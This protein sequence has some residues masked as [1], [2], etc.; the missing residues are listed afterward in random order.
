MVDNLKDTVECEIC[1]RRFV[2]INAQHLKSHNTTIFEYKKLYPNGKFNFQKDRTYEELYGE[3]RANKISSK[4]TNKNT[5]KKRSLKTI[6]NIKKNHKGMLGHN[7]T[8][9]PCLKCGKIHGHPRSMK[10]KH[11]S[12]EKKNKISKRLKE[13]KTG[14]TFIDLYGIEKA[15][16]IKKK[17]SA[18]KKGVPQTEESKAKHIKGRIEHP[19]SEKS[20]EKLRQRMLSNKFALGHKCSDNTL[21]LMSILSKKRWENIEYREKQTQLILEAL[22]IKPTSIENT[23]FNII[24]A[25]YKLPFKYCGD[26]SF[27]IGNKNPDG[28]INDG[29]QICVEINGSYWHKPEDEQERINYFAKYGWKCIVIWDYELKNVVEVVNKV[30]NNL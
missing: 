13:I 24:C 23:F 8:D 20:R 10:G 22:M 6:E 30:R 26:G 17:I 19:M 29:R 3:E 21:E 9:T 28:I 15:N 11:C 12:E 14:K 7:R 1:H 18:A 27:L 25:K 2:F 4:I 16:E 5:G